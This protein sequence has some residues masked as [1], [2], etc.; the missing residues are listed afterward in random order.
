MFCRWCA[1]GGNLFCCSY[2]SNTFCNKCLKRN[3]DSDVR[4]RIEAEEQWKCFVCDP[5][6]L[7]R[8]RGICRALLQ[9]IEKVTRFVLSHKLIQITIYLSIFPIAGSS[10]TTTICRWPRRRRRCTWT[11]RPVATLKGRIAS[12]NVE[13]AQWSR[14]T[15]TTRR[16]IRQ[17]RK[18]QPPSARN[19]T[20]RVCRTACW[21]VRRRCPL[22]PKWWF[23]RV[24]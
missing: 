8:I 16:T 12:A 5:T 14:T 3:L 10:K 9:H 18:S 7:F 13:S 4:K 22:R 21:I 23:P 20:N 11:S 15:T 17:W 6:D 1:N 24:W 2:C 19:S